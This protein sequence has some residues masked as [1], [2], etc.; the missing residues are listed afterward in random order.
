[1]VALVSNDPF[2][3]PEH[4]PVIQEF[5]Q[6]MPVRLGLTAEV[7]HQ[8]VAAMNRLLAHAT[9]LRDLYKK[10]HWQT[11]GSSFYELHQLFDK[12]HEEQEALMDALA[13]RVQAFGGV[14]RALAQGIVEETRLAR[15]PSGIESPVH[16][17][18]R[19]VAAHEFVLLEAR[20]LAAAASSR[21]DDGTADLIVSQVVRCNEQQSWF[22]SRHIQTRPAPERRPSH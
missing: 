18:E 14:A 16:Q 19:L 22:V 20:P 13:E 9:A 8:G 10:S 1:M 17:L 11:S 12:H 21:G 5:D 7:R 6:L 3:H 15:G 2:L 4:A